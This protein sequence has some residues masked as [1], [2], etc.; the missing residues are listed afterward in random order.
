MVSIDY[1]FHLVGAPVIV[2]GMLYLVDH[3]GE[4]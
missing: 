4:F 1:P 2:A 3:S